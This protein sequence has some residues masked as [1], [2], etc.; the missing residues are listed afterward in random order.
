MG[1]VALVLTGGVAKGA[2][3]AGVI[4]ALAERRVTPDVIVG[5]SAGAINGTFAASAIAHGN[6]RPEVVAEDLCWLW[7]H[8]VN[9]RNLYDGGQ[10]A[11][12]TDLAKRSLA[13]IFG[14]LG[15][16]PLR[17]Q[18]LPRIGWDTLVA[19][20]KL[21]R[22]EFASLISHDFLQALLD[23]RLF[24]VSE[25]VREVTLSV[26]TT[27]LQGATVMTDTMDIDARFSHYEDF[28]WRQ[29]TLEEWQE[30]LPRLSNRILAS[31]SFPFVFP[32]RTVTDAE[33]ESRFHVD[34]GMMDCAPVGRAIKMDPEVDTIL[35]SLGPTILSEDLEIA[36]T[37]PNMMG[38]VMTIMAGRFIIA[39][40]RKVVRVNKQLEALGPFLDKDAKG[41]TRRSDRNDALCRAAGFKG[42]DDFLGRRVVR[43]VPIAPV[44]GLSGGVFDGFFKPALLR[45][46]I[47]QGYK[48]TLEAV[49][50]DDPL[51]AAPAPRRTAG[52]RA[53][54][55]A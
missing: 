9:A 31:S 39:N 4:Q 3:E 55:T 16:D 35:V 18:Y 44:G 38:R 53:R 5:I 41:K 40:Y 29:R 49:G 25:V 28:T 47:A 17:R 12:D 20:E 45:E 33:G 34:G 43:L 37:L 7:E 27:N 13:S 48:D 23:S 36:P 11:P 8:K 30:F 1:K 6:F 52:R 15:I 2:Y 42:I 14:R 24:P 54:P 22:G 19:F 32:P 10:R 26:V 46:Y 21:V 51:V 50:P